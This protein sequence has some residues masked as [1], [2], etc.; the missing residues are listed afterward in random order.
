[1]KITQKML[2]NGVNPSEYS[3]IPHMIYESDFNTNH[4]SANRIER[5]AREIDEYMK[6]K[7]KCAM[8]AN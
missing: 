4:P 2:H 5:I 8:S 3:R 1:M 6:W 7:R